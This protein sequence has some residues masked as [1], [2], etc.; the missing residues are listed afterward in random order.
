MRRTFPREREREREKPNPFGLV[1][2]TLG[3]KQSARIAP[4]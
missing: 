3:G 1:D 2:E 4:Q